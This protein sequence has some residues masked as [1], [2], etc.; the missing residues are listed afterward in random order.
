MSTGA[1]AQWTDCALRFRSVT[2][3]ARTSG[4]HGWNFTGC[5]LSGTWSTS[6]PTRRG[7]EAV[8]TSLNYQRV[9]SAHYFVLRGRNMGTP[10]MKD[11]GTFSISLYRSDFI[12]CCSILCRDFFFYGLYF[13]TKA[14]DNIV[15][16]N[17]I[18]R[19]FTYA[20]FKPDFVFL[21]FCSYKVIHSYF[22]FL[23]FS[24]VIAGLYISDQS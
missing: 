18:Y 2:F 22:L 5:L 12:F 13:A 1:S 9:A 3:P 7:N 19:P 4:K 17:C 6:R 10:L 24:V 11:K 14:S 16:Y 20:L 21:R 8:G 23:S 15:K